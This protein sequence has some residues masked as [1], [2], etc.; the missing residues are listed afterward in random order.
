[1]VHQVIESPALQHF[2]FGTTALEVVNR[3]IPLIARGAEHYNL[4]LISKA[5]GK[6]APHTS[7]WKHILALQIP[8]SGTWEAACKSFADGSA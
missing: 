8:R 5:H 7:K 1:M 6:A 4:A 3:A 2:S